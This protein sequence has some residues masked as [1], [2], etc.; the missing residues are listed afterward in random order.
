MATPSP[1][2]AAAAA[3]LV[4]KLA[5]GEGQLKTTRAPTGW[6]APALGPREMYPPATPPV[7]TAADRAGGFAAEIARLDE[8]L[9]AIP[10]DGGPRMQQARLGLQ[11]RKKE[12]LA[13]QQSAAAQAG[14]D[15]AAET[16]RIE[17]TGLGGSPPR[18]IPYRQ[19]TRLVDAPEGMTGLAPGPTSDPTKAPPAMRWEDITNALR[20]FG[21]MGEPMADVPEPAPAP[22][23]KVRGR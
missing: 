13:A 10:A 23:R 11:A 6:A 17:G 9:A 20:T 2:R 18:D 8:M 3:A 19:Q 5:T 4:E 12:A 15:A 21:Q 7:I 14:A 22:T 1:Q 16:A